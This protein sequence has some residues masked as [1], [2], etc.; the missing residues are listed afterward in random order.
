[1]GNT[2][3]QVN[4]LQE[5][6]MQVASGL[7][8]GNSEAEQLI[9]Y[10]A[11]DTESVTNCEVFIES[12]NPVEDQMRDPATKPYSSSGHYHNA[13]VRRRVPTDQ[14]QIVCK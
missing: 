4:V 9:K 11:T 6:D 12:S 2:T 8:T 3:S 7:E 1:M 13:F 10:V 14:I 5:P